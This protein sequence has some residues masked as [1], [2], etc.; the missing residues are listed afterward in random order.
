MFIRRVRTR[1]TADGSRYYSCRLVENYRVGKRVRQR[2]LLNLGSQFDFPREQWPELTQRIEQILVGQDDILAS[3]S[4]ALEQCAQTTVNL[5]LKKYSRT[6]LLAISGVTQEKETADKVKS[7]IDE[8]DL[9][10]VDLNSVEHSN[11]RTVGGEALAHNAMLEVRLPER[12]ESMGFNNSQVHAAMGNIVGRMLQPG[13]ELSTHEWLQKRSGLGDLLDF[14]FEKQGLSALYR[15]SDLLWENHKEIEDYL[16]QQ[17]VSMFDLEECITLYDLTNTFFEGSGK[18][19]SLA[20][21]GHSKE[22]RSD[23]PL[24]TLALVLDGSGFSRRSRIFPGNISEPSTL[25][26]IIEQLRSPIDPTVEEQENSGVQSLDL[27]PAPTI[28]MDAGIASEENIL[29]LREHDYKYIV[30]SR[31]RHMEFDE[32]CSVVVKE[33]DNDTVRAMRVERED[34]EIELYCHSQ[35]KEAKEDAMQQRVSSRLEAELKY[36]A[37]GLQTPRRLKNAKKV[38][39]KIGRLRQKYSRASRYY[40]ISIDTDDKEKIATALHYKRITPESDD[41]NAHPG[42]YC[43]RSNQTQWDEQ[44]LW[45]TYTMLTD[46]EAVFRSLK[47]E[48]G[49]RPVYHQ[50][51]HRVE[52]H[53]FITLLAY[54]LVHQVR[55]KLKAQGIDD[56]WDKIR[57]TMSTQVR[58]TTSM[59]GETGKQIHIRRSCR[60]NTDQKKLLRALGLESLPGK[61]EKTIVTP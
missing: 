5:L 40:D 11:S 30:V 39:E 60:P 50:R 48:L 17:H 15:V 21:F 34:G 47:S 55:C 54:N 22:R 18:Y 9:H 35:G 51:T 31:K 4:D 53:I 32:E 37:E 52:A 25:Q 20:E 38:T 33:R 49:M 57:T 42:V 44:Q 59:R 10:T 1:T 7:G 2:T 26:Q 13:S 14:E 6:E 12:L 27:R 8:K 29:W 46:L 24:V 58:V 56:S 41:S 19:N 45:S 36:L 23:C 16:Y 28:I 43:L 3:F 61:T